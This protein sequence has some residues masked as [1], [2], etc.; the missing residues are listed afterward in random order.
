MNGIF[1]TVLRG[2]QSEI[3]SSFSTNRDFL[4]TYMYETDI[5]KVIS[6]EYIASGK[7]SNTSIR[8]FLLKGSVNELKVVYPFN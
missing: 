1:S 5:D 3:K 2:N 7:G 4:I 6:G 8:Y